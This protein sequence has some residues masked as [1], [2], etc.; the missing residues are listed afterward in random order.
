MLKP[1]PVLVIGREVLKT[2]KAAIHEKWEAGWPRAFAKAKSP[3]HYLAASS[4]TGEARVLFLAG[5]DSMAAWEK[6]TEANAKN[7]ALSAEL[8]MLTEKDAD[9]LQ[10]NRTAV[11]SYMPELSYQPEIPVAGARYFLIFSIEV[12]P[13]HGDHFVATRKIAREAHEKA[14]L[15]DHYAVYRLVA[16]RSAGFFLIIVPMKSL[17]EMDQFPAM[18]NGK[19]YQDALGDDGRK[20]MDDFA[21]Q[22][23]QSNEPQ[24]FAFSPKM[25]YASKE[26]IDADPDFWAPKPAPKAA[27]KAAPTQ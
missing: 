22:G 27:K 23:V 1:P 12:K 13:G 26:W 18:H 7:A 11:F 6:D 17:A 15:S 8:N 2:G 16:G 3:S 21:A 4:L 14:R 10:E 25:S 19:A 5:F 20:K 9:Y 24:I